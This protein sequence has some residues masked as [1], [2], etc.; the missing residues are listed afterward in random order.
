[1]RSRTFS[2]DPTWETR[3]VKKKFCIMTK[4]ITLEEE[5][6]NAKTGVDFNT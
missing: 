5:V 2:E 6:G 3:D 1:M 4:M